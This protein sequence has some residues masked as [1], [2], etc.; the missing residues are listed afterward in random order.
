VSAVIQD[1]DHD[2][3]FVLYGFRFSGRS[4]FLCGFERKRL[5]AG[6]LRVSAGG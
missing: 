4:D 1:G 3:P 5:F 6:E 2:V